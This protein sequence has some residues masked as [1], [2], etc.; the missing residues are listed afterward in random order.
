MGP[1]V[2]A[3]VSTLILLDGAATPASDVVLDGGGGGSMTA[4]ADADFETG[5]GK[6]GKG[7]SPDVSMVMCFVDGGVWRNV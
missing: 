7:S 3:S 2:E 1:G 6:G 5:S 4:G